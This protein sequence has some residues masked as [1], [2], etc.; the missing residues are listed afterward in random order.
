L[1]IE[2]TLNSTLTDYLNTTTG[3]SSTFSI[4]NVQIMYDTIIT[5]EAISNSLYKSLLANR[6]LSM[7]ALIPYMTV[8]TIPSGSTSFSFAAVRA[9]SRLSHIYLSFRGTGG[10][11]SEFICPTAVSGT[12]ATPSLSDGVGPSARLSIGPH[13][14]PDPS[15][16]SSLPEH[17]YQ[18]IRAMDP[19]IPNITRDSFQNSA[20][21]IVFDLRKQHMD[22]T[23]SVSTR[24]GDL[25][26]VDLTNL[27]TSTNAPTE[28][29]MVMLAFGVVAVRESGIT[30]LT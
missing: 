20:F 14:W 5:D 6:V 10:K 22:P 11:S 27:S 23:T 24:S 8:Q 15:P 12:G 7:P 4:S 25:V 26:R 18:M 3:N 30:L 19:V 21:T 13:L 1:E 9:F 17:Y 2:M 28:V 16:I 29:W